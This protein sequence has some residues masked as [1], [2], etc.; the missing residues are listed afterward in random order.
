MQN[1][2]IK[3]TNK[4]ILRMLHGENRTGTF[5]LTEK[6]IDGVFSLTLEVINDGNFDA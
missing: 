4:S 6:V 2:D 5:N 1:R 3:K